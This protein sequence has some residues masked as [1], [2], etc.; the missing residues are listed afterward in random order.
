MA[1]MMELDKAKEQPSPDDSIPED[2]DEQSGQRC[3]IYAG[4]R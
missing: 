3:A 1:F 4:Q 2:S